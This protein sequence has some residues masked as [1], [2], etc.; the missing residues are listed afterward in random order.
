MDYE[1]ID[2]TKDAQPAADAK[3]GKTYTHAK[4]VFV[5]LKIGQSIS[6]VFL[7]SATGHY[8]LMYRMKLNDGRIVFLSGGRYQL[9]SLME[10]LDASDDFAGGLRGH[11][12][13]VYRGENV[14]LDNGTVVATF[15]VKHLSGC[16]QGCTAL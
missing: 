6:G 7:R 12:I 14:S 5:S 4:P 3:P 13:E 2:P 1:K 9:D 11:L 8:G 10:D 16:P 15:A